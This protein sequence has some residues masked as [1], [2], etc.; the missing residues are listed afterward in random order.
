VTANPEPDDYQEPQE[1]TL[2]IEVPRPFT[3]LL[4]KKRY[5]GAH[6]GRG[7]CKSH[8]FA[9]QLI[10]WSIEEPPLR[11]VCVREIQKSLEQSVKRLLEDKIKSLDVGSLFR[12]MNN[13]IVTPGGGLIIFQGMQNHTAESI[14][15]LEAYRGAW[16][17]EAQTLSQTSLDLLRPTLRVEGSELWFSWNPR[18][19][20]DPVD[21]FFRSGEPP[22]DSACVEV[23]YLDNPWLPDV[24]KAEAD[25]DRRR[26]P[27]K[28]AHVWGG[29]YIKNSEARVFKNWRVEEFDTP[30]TASFLHGGDWGFATDPTVLLRMWQREPRVLMIDAE[31]YG[32]GVEIDDT[33]D[34]FDGLLC[35][36][37][38]GAWPPAPV[39]HDRKV[40][41][42]PEH[43]KAREWEVRADSARPETISYVKRHGYTRIV[44]AN[45]GPNSVEE[46]VKFLKNYDIIIHPRCKRT[47]DEFTYYSY[48]VDKTTGVVLP[49]LQDE[50][51][52]VI[53][54][55]RYA[56]ERLRK[57]KAGLVF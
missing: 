22:P 23:N 4:G 28:Y 34:F 47:I 37:A 20:T 16:V 51:N 13:E 39:G 31:R 46:G 24:L 50:K 1:R 36:D 10:K 27:D 19:A 41:E 12:I 11:F 45:K 54:S 49:I 48:K 55:A 44:P 32:V 2:R 56:V 30:S 9:E 40:C 15:S 17:E 14:K 3:P 43:G 35:G 5:K 6:G 33:P 18:H 29:K 53:D 21:K 7:G 57:A 42:R 25:W 26:D 52:H 8:F 38:C